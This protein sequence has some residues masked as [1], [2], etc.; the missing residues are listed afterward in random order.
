MSTRQPKYLSYIY[1]SKNK[2]YFGEYS[3]KNGKTLQHGNGL[4]YHH[5]R[6]SK[7]SKSLTNHLYLGY[8]NYGISHFGYLYSYNV[9]DP[10]KN[11]ELQTYR[12][13]ENDNEYKYKP[14]SIERSKLKDVSVKEIKSR[15][16]QPL[17]YAFINHFKEKFPSLSSLQEM[18]LKQLKKPNSRFTTVS[19]YTTPKNKSRFTTVTRKSSTGRRSGGSKKRKHRKPKHR[20]RRTKAKKYK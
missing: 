19:R 2:V 3:R 10:E 7:D 13:D 4:Q 20:K 9:N 14:L 1:P 16:T 8:W 6:H 15:I 18:I 17:F 5:E 11:A 12:Y